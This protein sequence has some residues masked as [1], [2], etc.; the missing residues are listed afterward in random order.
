M[1]SML[2]MAA[3]AAAACLAVP[4]GTAW[5]QEGITA[6]AGGPSFCFYQ[7]QKF[8]EGAVLNGR[9][10]TRGIAT[11]GKAAEL[12]WAPQEAPGLALMQLELERTRLQAQLFQA[13]SLLADAEAHYREATGKAAGK[14]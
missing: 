1:K 3:A 13:R 12:I 6:K 11:T 4:A 2:V 5:A 9:V 10:C 8:S 7:D 14:N